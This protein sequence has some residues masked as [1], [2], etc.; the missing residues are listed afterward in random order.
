MNYLPKSP[1]NQQKNIHLKKIRTNLININGN[2]FSKPFNIITDR[3]NNKI[4]Q[5]KIYTR[6]NI[7]NEDLDTNVTKSVSNISLNLKNNEFNFKKRTKISLTKNLTRTNSKQISLINYT[8][9]NKRKKLINSSKNIKKFLASPKNQDIKIILKNS[10]NIGKG[11]K[12]KKIKRELLLNKNQ[13]NNKLSYNNTINSLRK[14]SKKSFETRRITNN[15]TKRSSISINKKTEEN[16][17]KNG[18]K[19]SNIKLNKKPIKIET[20][21][22]YKERRDNFDN[23]IKN[24]FYFKENKNK[25]MRKIKSNQNFINNQSHLPHSKKRNNINIF[26]D[27]YY[28]IISK[29]NVNSYK[30]VFP[31]EKNKGFKKEYF[32]DTVFIKS[33]LNK[34]SSN[35]FFQSKIIN[36]TINKLIKFKTKKEI[37]KISNFTDKSD[38]INN[39]LYYTNK[40]ARTTRTKKE[41]HK[42]FIKIKNNK[43]MKTDKNK[44]L[45]KKDKMLKIN[46]DN[47]NCNKNDN[48]KILVDNYQTSKFEQFNTLAIINVPSIKE[49]NKKFKKNSKKKENSSINEDFNSLERNS[50]PFKISEEIINDP[51]NIK[52]IYLKKKMKIC[53]SFNNREKRYEL[54]ELFKCDNFIRII[55]SFCEGD[56]DLL[57]KI[58][59]ISKEIYR[60]MKPF[61][62]KKISSKISIY[63]SNISTKNKIK[64]QLMKSNSALFKLTPSILHIKYNDLL[65]ENN[66]YDN[67]IKKDLTRTF[68]DNI[69]FKYGNIYYNKLYH[70]LT[71]YSNLNK[72]IGYVQGINYIAAQIIFIYENEIDGLIFLDALINKTELDKI[73]D[74]N[75]NNEY[76][77]KIFKNINIFIARQIPRLDK[78][79]TEK[80]LNIEFFTMSWIL[81][82]FSDSMDTEFLVLIWDYM[83]VFGWKFVKYFILN[84]L[85]KSQ[86]EILNST[87]S[88]LTHTKKNLLKNGKFKTNFRKI[89][90]DTEQLLISDVNIT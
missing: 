13:S 8:S 73:L 51:D 19:L 57:N 89:I 56:I 61:I 67:E 43:I 25:K 54:Y 11:Y 85:L 88:D 47:D 52:C 55:F 39:F 66:K 82:L 62:Y 84:I 7:Y 24:I 3:D 64:K 9:S 26:G 59:V 77:E 58:S 46:T 5:I 14:S 70:I 48:E 83:I 23:S 2:K 15:I 27:E 29:S 33:I 6:L 37:S 74:N 71:A 1:I 34:T 86:N 78:F 12:Y 45:K 80:K 53:K 21:R 75:L 20:N 4:S 69:L 41:S 28:Q 42:N 87:Q 60:K 68:P 31:K 79:L 40:T 36:S 50:I 76:Y 90:K 17:P 81:T 30:N 49:Q 38:G 18:G 10:R 72:N 16:N 32:K 44:L 65:L 22:I 35:K 63:N